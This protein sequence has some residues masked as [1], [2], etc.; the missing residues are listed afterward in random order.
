MLGKP[1]VAIEFLE[2]LGLG[3]VQMIPTEVSREKCD[4]LCL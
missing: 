4:R 3:K 2:D 1:G